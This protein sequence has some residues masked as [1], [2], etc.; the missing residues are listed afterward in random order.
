MGSVG[1]ANDWLGIVYC[2]DNEGNI[3]FPNEPPILSLSFLGFSS[4]LSPDIFIE[5]HERSNLQFI[6]QFH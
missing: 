1:L 6:S 5:H 4:R 2:I 3:A